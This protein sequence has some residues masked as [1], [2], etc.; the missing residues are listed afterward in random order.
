MVTKVSDDELYIVVNAG[1][2]DKDL[3]HLNKHLAPFKVGGWA[4]R[5]HRVAGWLH[6]ARPAGQRALTA[7]QQRRVALGA[8]TGRA[9]SPAPSP[10]PPSP[11]AALRPHVCCSQ[12]KGGQ[13]DLILH[14]DRSLLAL[15]G[16][17]APAVLQVR[18]PA[19]WLPPAGRAGPG[20]AGQ[21]LPASA[22]H[23]GAGVALNPSCLHPTPLPL[24]THPSCL[25]APPLLDTHH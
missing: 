7:G 10:A 19:W 3:A 1:C 13:V 5:L 24:E 9:P 14:D 2:R 23:P 20:R 22:S 17:Q 15:Q 4:E 21:L 6:M 8:G 12:A 18:G 16:P 25:P 11:D